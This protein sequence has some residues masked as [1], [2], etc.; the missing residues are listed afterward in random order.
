MKSLASS[1]MYCI[2]SGYFP[3]PK[4]L[5]ILGREQHSKSHKSYYSLNKMPKKNI[6]KD[7]LK[8]T[9]KFLP[10]EAEIKVKSQMFPIEFRVLW[11]QRE[12]K[13]ISD[14]EFK[15]RLEALKSKSKKQNIKRKTKLH[16]QSKPY[17]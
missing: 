6:G 13:E 15:R 16:H 7:V 11:T 3:S 1:F 5:G 8:K 17:V 4:N 9:R 10:K 12:N 2:I 14:E